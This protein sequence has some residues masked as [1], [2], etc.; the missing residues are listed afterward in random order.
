MLQ[1]LTNSI[2]RSHGS[3]WIL[4]SR[5]SSRWALLCRFRSQRSTR[6]PFVC[7]ATRSGG[8]KQGESKGCDHGG[9]KNTPR[10]GGRVHI[11]AVKA[12]CHNCPDCLTARENESTA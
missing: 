4:Q 2:S 5:R 9:Q 1:G 8:I 7:A 11:S 12:N 10:P 6:C 3:P